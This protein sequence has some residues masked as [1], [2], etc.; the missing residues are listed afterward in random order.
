MPDVFFKRHILHLIIFAASLAVYIFVFA[1]FAKETAAACAEIYRFNH[2]SCREA[3]VAATDPKPS[4]DSFYNLNGVESLFGNGKRLF[5]DAYMVKDGVTYS[6]NAI[7]FDG[8][9]NSGECFISKNA[10]K[11]YGL[12][13]GDEITVKE[14]NAAYRVAGYL[15]AQVGLDGRYGY[16]GVIL[17]SFNAELTVGAKYSNLS[18]AC[19]VYY[20]RENSTFLK[21]LK[22]TAMQNIAAAAIFAAAAYAV[23][24]AV[25]EYFIFSQRYSDYT[26]MNNEGLS[27]RKLLARIT[28]DTF[29]KYVFPLMLVMAFFA[30][31]PGYYGKFYLLPSAIYL[32]FAAIVCGGYSLILRRRFT[33]CHKIRA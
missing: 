17:L 25:C 2:T 15:A 24:F 33:K 8:T 18:G 31:S 9:V 4:G 6:D 30:P 23:C 13:I 26:L 27:A 1:L 32:L 20:G 7:L 5:C 16:D 11:E 3:V 22:K 21:N 28:L 10:A 29:F 14:K 19:D 12:K